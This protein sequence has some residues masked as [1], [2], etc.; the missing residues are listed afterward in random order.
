MLR[1]GPV[2][3]QC[4]RPGRRRGSGRRAGRR[5]RCAGWRATSAGRAL[6]D[7]PAALEHQQPV[8]EHHR[9][10][11]VVGDQQRRPAEVATGAG[12]A[13]PA[14]PAGCRA[15]SAASGSSSSSSRAARPGP[16]P[17]PPAAPA[18]RTAAAACGRRARSGRPGQASLRRWP[19]GPPAHAPGTRPERHVVQ[20]AQVREQQVVLEHQADR[21]ARG[22]KMPGAGVVD[23]LP[24]EDDA[25]V[26]D[27]R[28][29]RPARAAGWSCRRRSARARR[30][31]RP[32]AT[33]ERDVEREAPRLTTASTT[34]PS[35][36]R[37]VTGPS[38]RAQPAVAQGDQHQHGDHQQH[39]AQRDRRVG[40]GLQR[41]VDR[42]AAWSGCGRG[43]CRRR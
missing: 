19:G 36:P 26:G 17:A 12:A 39:Q 40:V 2:P 5:T 28:R 35:L 18:R 29:A 4:R 14:R 16:G 32:G 30:A 8:G 22:T 41:E 34:R 20:H 1:P 42:D 43:S 9:L 25:A 7:D 6:L 11:R 37:G 38:R 31:P 21:P 24:G 10:E 23:D 27:R 33:R 3:P 13:R 15:S